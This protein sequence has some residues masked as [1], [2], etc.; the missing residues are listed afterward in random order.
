MATRFRRLFDTNRGYSIFIPALFKIFCESENIQA[1]RSAII[2]TWI[3]FFN[4]QGESFIFQALGC[5][6][7]IILKGSAKSTTTGEWICASLYDLFKALNFPAKLV[8]TLG[9]FE[10]GR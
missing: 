5:L 2:F 8:D 6:T 3:K 4:V 10:C 9:I 1:I 7:P